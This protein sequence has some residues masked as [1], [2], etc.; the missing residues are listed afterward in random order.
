MTEFNEEER[1]AVMVC[2]NPYISKIDEGVITGLLRKCKPEDSVYLE[3][4]LDLTKETRTNG[5]DSCTFL[6]RW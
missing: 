2:D 5:G 4:K 1:S 3:V 6:L